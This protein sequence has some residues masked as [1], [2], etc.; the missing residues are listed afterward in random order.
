MKHKLLTGLALLAAMF[1]TGLASAE[2]D[3]LQFE[4]YELDGRHA[5]L[6]A[7]SEAGKTELGKPWIWY[8]PT[9]HKKLPNQRDEGW[10]IER[11]HAK[12]IAVAGIDVGESFGSPKGRAIFQ[13]LYEHMVEQGYSTKPVLL[14][15]SRGGLM[16]YNWAVEHPECVAGVA[17]VYPVCNLVSYPG[18]K[19]AAPAYDLTEAQLKANLAKHNPIDRLAPLA[20]AKVPLYHLHGDNDRVVPLEANSGLLASRYKKL[21]GPVTL[22]VI[23]DGGHDMKSHW[24]E[25]Q[26]LT[27]FMIDK[28]TN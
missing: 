21:G 5:F 4:R 28:A 3:A 6:L 11:L 24:F 9:F 17:G 20:K 2:Q 13:Q 15:R 19:K 25:S 1:L 26:K 16:L 23:K 27:D 22:E 14:A 18:L 7:P 8:A 12:G 10:M